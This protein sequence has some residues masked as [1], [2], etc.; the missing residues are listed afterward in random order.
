MA[1]VYKVDF[2]TEPVKRALWKQYN[3][4]STEAWQETGKMFHVDMR[5]RRFTESHGREAGYKKRKAKYTKRKFCEF[6]HK[7]P[8]ER[9]GEVKRLVKSAK[10]VARGGTGQRGNQGGARVIYR[11]ARKLN[12]INPHSDINMRAE[13]TRITEREAMTLGIA[14]GVR[15]KEKFKR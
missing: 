8:L 2:R 4:A 12:Y 14:H 6:G 11:G 15:L 5:P 7:N 1:V 3:E 13:F 10:I 9:T